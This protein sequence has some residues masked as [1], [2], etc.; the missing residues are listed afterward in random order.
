MI[1]RAAVMVLGL[2][3]FARAETVVTKDGQRLQGE[4]VEESQDELVLR[5]RYGVLV[6][7][8]S[9]IAAVE[10][11]K[12]AAPAAVPEGPVVDLAKARAL[13][14]KARRLAQLKKTDEA[15]AAW[16][17][18]LALDPDDAFAHLELGLLHASAGKKAEAVAALRKAILGGFTDFERL[19]HERELA[20]LQGDAAF[21]QL[22]AQRA[23]L[24]GLAA[25][26]TPERIVRDLRARGARGTYRIARDEARKL[27]WVHALEEAALA[28]LRGEVEA[29][30]AAVRRE[31]F[32]TAPAGTLF[33]VLLA[34]P[35]RDLIAPAASSWERATHTLQLAPF[36]SVWKSAAAQRELVRA[37]HA[38]DQQARGER[39]PAWLEEGLVELLG[40]AAPA[41]ER[42]APRPAALVKQ[43]DAALKKDAAPWGGILGLERAAFEQRGRTARLAA[44]HVLAW[45]AEKGALARVYDDLGKAAAGVDPDAASRALESVGADAQAAWR[46][47]VAEQKPPELPFT[48]LVTS[49]GPQGLRVTY[50]QAESGAARANLVEGDVVVSV[51]G[52]PVRSEDD[53]AE[54]LG[55]RAIGDAVEVEVVSRE[56]RRRVPVVLAA[57]PPGPIGPVREKAPYLGVAVEETAPGKLAIRSVDEGSPAA[58]AG[59]V[60]GDRVVSLDGAEVSSVRAWLRALRLKQAGQKAALALERDGKPVTLEVELTTLGD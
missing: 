55:A 38:L 31:P 2:A 53:L 13:R 49:P 39:H 11:R 22:L 30:I 6:L 50:V 58:K 52:A 45:V 26:R 46:T 5:T 34:E 47:W 28:P 44:R 23:G 19:R 21:Q 4:V 14:L 15:V 29:L 20:G 3:L 25:R 1:P 17:E 18:L 16:S 54:V 42:L 33:L 57:R 8:T 43:L 36:V 37:L 9:A 27:V 12:G 7:P 60:A 41:G 56:Q 24:A 40:T 32:T 10:G 48:G 51:D 59:L 35:D